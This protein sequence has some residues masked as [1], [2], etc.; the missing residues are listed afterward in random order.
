[1]KII[2][3]VLGKGNPNRMNGVNKV[4][5][6]LATTQTQMGYDV[7]LWGIA[8]NLEIN[9]PDRN[10]K[11]VLFQQN[12]NKLKLDINLKSS[13][14]ALTENTIVHIHGSFIPEFFHVSK[15]L[16]K[17]NIDYIYT[18]H[19]ALTKGAMVKNNF[20]KKLYF[21]LFESTLIKN[22]K[23]MQLLGVQEVE[24]TNSLINSNN[25]V[26]IPNG[27]DLTVIPD[28]EEVN[29]KEIVFGFCGR[30]AT[31]HKGLDLL[32]EGFK[33]FLDNGN[34]GTL[35]LIGDSDER[36]KLETHCLELGIEKK[37]IFHGKKFGYEKF[38][39]IGKFDVFMHTSRMEG[40]PTA[41][42]EASGM[43]KVCIT[44][45]ATNIN[46]YL[47]KFD[48]GLPMHTNTPASIAKKM[49]EALELFNA[50]KLSPIGNR[51]KEMVE[52]E[53]SWTN[54]SQQLIEVYTK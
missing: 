8:N 51:A 24:Y 13:I 33:I 46:D 23:A 32:F 50:D 42:L 34:N 49:E 4:A 3:I 26:L 54:V 37:V 22:A 15:L 45:E 52:N 40:F 29:N 28:L 38:K 43:G 17:K 11:T 48:A 39:L 18:P 35:E 47:R 1:M 19:G 16:S 36:L 21:E 31:F 2:H 5:Y 44:S 7:T 25:K 30:L 41:V 6:Q 14:N 20:A 12:K 27:Q 10:F 53:F 9:Y